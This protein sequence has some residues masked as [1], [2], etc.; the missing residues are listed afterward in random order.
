LYNTFSRFTEMEG[1]QMAPRKLGLITA[2]AAIALAT[3]AASGQTINGGEV[4][5]SGATLFSNFFQ[6]PAGTNDFIDVD[7]DGIFGF[8]P[9][10]PIFVDQLAT[11]YTNC[12]GFTT[13]WLVQYRG[14]GSVNGF[15]EFIDY[16]LLGTIP[17][18][19]PGELGVINRVTF[20]QGG[21]PV[22]TGCNPCNPSN[23]PYCP[24][25][26]DLGVLDVPGRWA[27]RSGES[28]NAKWD[29]TPGA[30]GYGVNTVPPTPDGSANCKA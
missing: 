26:I 1:S 12:G 13:W 7:G 15:G 29:R 6:S 30:N 14:V 2:A 24:S 25:G 22:G 19:V 28:A 4:N 5:I 18:S 9:Q 10:G 8:N 3:A 16:Q 27:V 23:T 11:G 20:A 21:S 17:E